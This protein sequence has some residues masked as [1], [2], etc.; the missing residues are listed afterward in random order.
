MDAREDHRPWGFYQVLSDEPTHKVKTIIVYPWQRLSLQ[1]HR[2]RREHWYL[3]QGQAI[4]TRDDTEISLIGGQSI[5]IPQGA[6]HRIMNAGGEN[7]IIIEVQT[8]SYFGEDDIE[9]AD[10]DYGR[11]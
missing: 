7:L 10:D 4:V 5:E 8:G 6:W 3:I 9:R 1:R 2:R 11:T